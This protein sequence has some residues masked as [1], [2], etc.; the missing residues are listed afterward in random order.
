MEKLLFASGNVIITESLHDGLEQRYSPSLL[1]DEIRSQPIDW[2]REVPSFGILLIKGN[3]LVC[4]STFDR[5]GLSP[6]VH[7]K[8]FQRSKE[9]RPES[10][11]IS[12]CKP[13]VFSSQKSGE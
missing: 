12:V 8:V 9:K 11:P 13:E 10:A 1:V 2:L 6:L 7:Q 5:T 3:D 4:S